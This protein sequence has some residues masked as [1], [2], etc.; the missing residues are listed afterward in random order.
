MFWCS[1]KSKSFAYTKSLRPPIAS[2]GCN[3]KIEIA[4]IFLRSLVQEH[5]IQTVPAEEFTEFPRH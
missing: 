5:E 3:L 4:M 2:S 1:V